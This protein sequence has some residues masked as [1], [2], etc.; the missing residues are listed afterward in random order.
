[1]SL[2][3]Q[4]IATRLLISCAFLLSPLFAL[5]Q[6]EDKDPVAILELG[7]AGGWSITDSGSSFAPAIAVEVTPIEHWLELEAGVTPFFSSHGTEWNVDLLFKKPWTLSHKAE[8]MAGIGPEWVHTNL[9]G[10]RP[11]SLAAE[12][13]LDVMFWPSKRHKFGWYLEPAYDSNLARGHE[14]SAGISG[15]LL[16]SIP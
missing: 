11:D 16:I 10:A 9:K 12:A 15:G 14:Q 4:A 5:S 6:Q 2:A 1:M 3:T 7:S 13:A 8:L